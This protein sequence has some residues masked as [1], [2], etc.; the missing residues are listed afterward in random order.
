MSI[1][2]MQDI[3]IIQDVD[4]HK[5]GVQLCQG[6]RQSK[7][8]RNFDDEG[9]PII[10]FF[11]LTLLLRYGM[12]TLHEETVTGDKKLHTLEFNGFRNNRLPNM[13]AIKY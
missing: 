11:D 5:A 3:G 7:I 8:P 10:I 1:T 9:F 2:L 12:C 6:R 4:I 13:K